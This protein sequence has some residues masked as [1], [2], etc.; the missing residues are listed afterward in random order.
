MTRRDT[1]EE[2]QDRETTRR[3]GGKVV[4]PSPFH[5][6]VNYGS[7]LLTNQDGEFIKP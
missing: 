4:T 1:S 6:F 5:D 3:E 7:K 2:G